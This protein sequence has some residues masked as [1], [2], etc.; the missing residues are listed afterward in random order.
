MEQSCAALRAGIARVFM[1]S[2]V[3]ALEILR[4]NIPCM[5]GTSLN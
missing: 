3:T 5:P 1:H 2:V 4:R